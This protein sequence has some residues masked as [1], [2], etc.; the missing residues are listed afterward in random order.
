MAEIFVTISVEAK[1]KLEA[2]AIVN[3]KMQYSYC[4]NIVGVST[5]NPYDIIEDLE[6]NK[7]RYD[8]E[9]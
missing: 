3:S 5:D 8:Y 2:T 6:N 7:M 9:K 4:S 1:N